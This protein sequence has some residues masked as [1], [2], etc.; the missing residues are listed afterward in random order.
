MNILLTGASSFTGYWFAS[1]LAEAGHKLVTPLRREPGQ[2]EGVGAERVRRLSLVADIVPHCAFGSPRF[3]AL[4]GERDFDVLCHHAAEG[5]DAASADF[6]VAGAL[7]AGTLNL[8]RILPLMRERGLKAVAATGSVLE[9]DEGAGPSPRAAHSP[10]GLASRFSFETLKYWSDV[11]GVPASKFVVAQAFG[12][13]EE[14]RFVDYALRRWA[15]GEA[16]EV[17]APNHLGDHIHADLL[18]LAY[19]DFIGRI[20]QG[21]PAQR[22][23]PCGYL[24]TRGAF[25]E[26]L[27]RELGARLG[28]ESRVAR[29]A[30]IDAGEPPPRFNADSVDAEALGWREDLAWEALASYYRRR[31]FGA[32]AVPSS[33]RA[34]CELRGAV[35]V[36]NHAG[37]SGWATDKRGANPRFVRV[38]V[39][40]RE[41]GASRAD[42]FR[43]DLKELEISDGASGYRFVFPGALD[44]YS[45]HVVRID[46]RD[47]GELFGPGPVL[48]K[49]LVGGPDAT[50]PDREFAAVNVVDAS[51]EEEAVVLDLEAFGRAAAFERLA[52]ADADVEPLD[53]VAISH[54]YFGA[55]GLAAVRLR[56]R[57]RPRAGVET[58]R[59]SF[60]E[61]EAGEAA[62][63]V[64]CENLV[65][66]RRP[67]YFDGVKPE[68]IER[69]SGPGVRPD[70][71]AACGLATAHRIEALTRLHFGR[72]LAECGACLDWGAGSGRVAA[73]MMRWAASGLALTGVDVDGFNVAFARAQ[74]WGGDFLE[75]PFLPPLPFADAAFGA[76]YGVSVFTHL[77]EAA[78]WLWLSELRRLVPAGAPVIVT[79]HNEYAAVR[80][81]ENA[82]D[83]VA[84]FLRRGF[85]DHIP[86]S[87]LGPKL[88]EASYYRATFHSHK[89][90]RERWTGE[91][92]IVQ[93]YPRGNGATQDYVVLK[94]K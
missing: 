28:Y 21:G 29:V 34:A 67:D 66:A 44:V 63:R 70:Q 90:L 59:L 30:R 17:L 33:P 37:V 1:K 64:A 76:I 55:V 62:E 16:V 4:V 11:A 50:G 57:A 88:R 73:P 89:Y 18:G 25:A 47:S 92:E 61:A 81:M 24:E 58:F 7:A 74:A 36:A 78:Q 26:R 40:G 27:A 84:E 23:G 45:D 38:A 22:F 52:S 68:N 65:P 53:R 2:Y 93:I 83:Q 49:K 56:V 82:P 91:F 35:D 51:F 13:F 14:P 3:L 9:P 31:G 86:D 85:S 5:R 46:D 6:D 94:A 54:R 69:V 87:N 39:D 79:V 42:L 48:L 71:F 77:T 41:L 10:Y 8:R 80:T 43:R 20:G 60:A 15:E 75:A 72:G 32:K 12:P 19:A